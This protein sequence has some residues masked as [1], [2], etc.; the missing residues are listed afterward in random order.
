MRLRNTKA[1]SNKS[2]MLG[3]SKNSFDHSK[4]PSSLR[5][6]VSQVVVPTKKE[7]VPRL[8]LH[9]KLDSFYKDRRK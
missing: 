8:K 5:E 2:S 7:F 6:V 1:N 4:Q 3:V 9:Q